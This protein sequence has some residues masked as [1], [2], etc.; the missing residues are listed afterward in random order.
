MTEIQFLI[1]IGLIFVSLLV[2]YI[3]VKLPLFNRWYLPASLI[4]G[5]ILLALG[6]QIA[7]HYFPEWQVLPMFYEE[8]ARFPG[9]LINIVFASL[10]LGRNLIPIREVWKLAAPQAA[11]GQTLAWG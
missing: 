11:F 3:I 5:L 2:G 6:P 8:W 9:V 1:G 7:G 10:F 4:G